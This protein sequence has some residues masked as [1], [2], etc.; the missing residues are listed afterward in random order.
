ML[1]ILF[2]PLVANMNMNSPSIGVDQN[3]SL[4]KDKDAEITAVEALLLLARQPLG[5]APENIVQCIKRKTQSGLQ[6]LS[7][8]SKC[9]TKLARQAA[10]SGK[11]ADITPTDDL[12]EGKRN[13]LKRSA[14]GPKNG[15]RRKRVDHRTRSE[16]PLAWIEVLPEMGYIR[17]PDA[18]WMKHPSYYEH[19]HTLCPYNGKCIH[20]T[21]C[22][23][24]RFDAAIELYLR[25]RK[26][27]SMRDIETLWGVSRSALSRAI[28]SGCIS[29][30][31]PLE[32]S[33]S[34]GAH[35]VPVLD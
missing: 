21:N 28:N 32:P 20:S 3:L 34:P 23:K 35:F 8:K 4:L 30:D 27:V 5:P 1:H 25:H 33:S 9:M 11:A 16:H 17:H 7:N 24:L 6:V 13:V 22:R 12:A 18:G 26:N 15:S 19:E 31:S 10:I 29:L 14:P 2:P